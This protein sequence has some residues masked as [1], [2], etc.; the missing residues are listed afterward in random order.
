[1]SLPGALPAT[2]ESMALLSS[3][4]VGSASSSS[5]TGMH[6]MASRAE[7]DTVFSLE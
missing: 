5:M 7:G 2:K 1:M 3:S 4:M 6:P